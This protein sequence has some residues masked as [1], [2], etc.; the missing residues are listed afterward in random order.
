MDCLSGKRNSSENK[1]W[2]TVPAFSDEPNREKQM[3]GKIQAYKIRFGNE[4]IHI[5]K[6]KDK[7]LEKE[8]RIETGKGTRIVK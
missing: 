7:I 5:W 4:E 2:F 1:I 3:G 8:K 6:I